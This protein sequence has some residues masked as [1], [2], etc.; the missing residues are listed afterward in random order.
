M[1]VDAILIFYTLDEQMKG[2]ENLKRDL[3][4]IV[5]TNL[6]LSNEIYFLVYNLQT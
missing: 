4:F 2:S 1:F 6:V 5:V 3:L